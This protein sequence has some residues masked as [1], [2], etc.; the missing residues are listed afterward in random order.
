MC[1]FDIA[2]PN[3]CFTCL[4]VIVIVTDIPH[5][6]IMK[7]YFH[8][9]LRC[10]FSTDSLSNHMLF[11]TQLCNCKSWGNM[12]ELWVAHIP[13]RVARV[14]P[15]QH[16]LSINHRVH[17][18]PFQ[19][20]LCICIKVHLWWPWPG[21]WEHKATLMDVNGLIT[22]TKQPSPVALKPWTWTFLS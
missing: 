3:V 17:H 10:H 20:I 6:W 22:N 16:F 9:S 21:A 7:K 8:K 12:G 18:K 13:Y 19:V 15:K 2:M 1:F 14:S 4:K 5:L 11:G